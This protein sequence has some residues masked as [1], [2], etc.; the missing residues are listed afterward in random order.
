MRKNDVGNASM[1][2]TERT[3][4]ATA[5]YRPIA[6]GPVDISCEATPDGGFR[7]RS[8]IPL[9]PHDPNL[10]RMFRAAVEAQPGRAF[11]AERSGEGW[12]K[13]TYEACRPLVDALA[14]ALIERGLSPQRPLM[15]L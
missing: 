4:P 2:R 9:G 15:L 5:A 12:R 8:R 10:A 13:L 14:A 7:L 6:F 1:N 11:L 3:A